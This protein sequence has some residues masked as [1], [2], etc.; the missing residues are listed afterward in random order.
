VSKKQR[1]K[2]S[3]VIPRASL[4]LCSRCGVSFGSVK[5]R[6]FHE[7]SCKGRCKA[8]LEARVPCSKTAGASKKC[9][10]CS[11]QNLN[12]SEFSH[13]H[14]WVGRETRTCERCGRERAARGFRDHVKLCR[15][16][17]NACLD[18]GMPC[19]RVIS[20]KC[21]HCIDHK[22]ECSGFSHEHLVVRKEKTCD[23]CGN[24]V[25]SMVMKQH[26]RSCKGKCKACLEAGVPCVMTCSRKCESC[27]EHKLDCSDFS[28]NDLPDIE[29]RTCKRCRKVL[30][31]TSITFKSHQDSC[32]GKCERCL[33]LG[34]PCLPRS[35]TATKL[36]GCA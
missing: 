11:D 14:L 36:D 16:E 31:S 15:G 24:K 29:A 1:L 4:P 27:K 25:L 9:I 33:E 10:R 19:V 13:E 21:Q 7:K 35:K 23:R 2:P 26:L 6:D 8:C 17:C 20:G 5:H 32:I 34:A 12:C 3:N 18:A 30:E 22:L 28:H